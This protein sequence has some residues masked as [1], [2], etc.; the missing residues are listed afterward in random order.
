[1]IMEGQTTNQSKDQVQAMKNL[2]SGQVFQILCECSSSP[3]LFSISM[4]MGMFRI[5]NR[6]GYGF[7]SKF[8]NLIPD[9]LDNFPT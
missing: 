8:L 6:I 4:I 2:S 9:F 5:E 1:M 3:I 7:S